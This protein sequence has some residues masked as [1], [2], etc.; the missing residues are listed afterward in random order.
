MSAPTFD[1][2][3]YYAI[4]RIDTILSTDILSQRHPLQESAFIE[5]M[6]R[7]NELNHKASAIGKRISFKDDVRQFPQVTDITDAIR[8]YRDAVC[9]TRADG[10]L[11]SPQGQPPPKRGNRKKNSTN[12]S[13]L[14]FNVMVGKGILL[15]TSQYTIESE[16]GDDVC[17]L[18]GAHRLYL[19]RHIVRNF[20]EV[21]AVVMP[22]YPNPF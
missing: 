6:I 16:Y 7:L 22:N 1:V 8:E 5:V 10:H 4:Q 20:Q 9:H 11:I 14:T 17:F 15:Q 13:Q 3:T 18:Y 21:V 19:K 12:Y 2:N